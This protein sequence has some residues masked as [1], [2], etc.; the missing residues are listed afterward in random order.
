MKGVLNYTIK[1]FAGLLIF[2]GLP[3]LGWG[4]RNLSAYM[5]NPARLAFLGVI[6]VLQIFAI[7]YS[8]SQGDDK[9]N[10]KSTQ[11]NIDL[12][13][14]QLFSLAIIFIAPY[15]DRRE[16]FIIR[17]DDI[18]RY[19]GVIMVIPGFVLMQVAE[20]YL[21]KQFSIDVKLQEDHQ[22]IT[23]GPYK[24]IRHPRY[25]GIIIFFVGI[26]LTFLSGLA[27]VIAGLLAYVLIW[28]IIVEE[29]LLQKEFDGDWETYKKKTW[30]IIPFIF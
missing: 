4:F 12:L 13:L 8:G 14:I 10:Y 15:T 21:D 5:D 25:L 26:S 2:I 23:T 9:K 3:L 28:R 11:H 30:Y 22:L 18:V 29:K 24:L 17:I 1:L 7:S 27:L 16:I 19:L 6:F 20:K